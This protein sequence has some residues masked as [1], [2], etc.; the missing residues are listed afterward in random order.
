MLADVAQK[1]AEKS[2]K[3]EAEEEKNRDYRLWAQTTT[4][5]YN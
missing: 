3:K 2:A 1:V 4:Q 5:T